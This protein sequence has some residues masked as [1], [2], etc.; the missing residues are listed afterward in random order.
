MAKIF[1]QL[2]EACLEQL[3]T[4]PA[5]STQGRIFTNTTEARIKTDDGVNKRALIRNDQKMILG[6]NA[7]PANNIR[8]HRGAATT[9]QF[10]TGS[11]VTAEG[12]LSTTLAKISSKL[13]AYS[14]AGRPAVGNQG[15]QIW[16]TDAGEVQADTGA[17]WI[18]VGTNPGAGT[19]N[20]ASL[21]VS[22]YGHPV[23]IN[24]T[25]T[26]SVAANALTIAV[27]TQSGVNPS[28]LNPVYAVFR[29]LSATTGLYS[30]IALTSAL[31]ITVPNG[32]SLGQ[33]SGAPQYVWIYLINDAGVIDLGV[34]GVDVFFNETP[35]SAT[36]ISAA[37]TSGSVLYS[38]A[39]HVGAKPTVIVG[40]I[41][42]TEPAAG[43][44]SLSPT[45]LHLNPKPMQTATNW[46]SDGPLLIGAVTLAPT[47]GAT[48]VDRLI[49][50]REGDTMFMR[51][52]FRQTGA[53][54]NG[55][56][57]YLISV[58]A[59]KSIN[60]NLVSI[61]TDANTNLNQTDSM[62][63]IGGRGYMGIN[64]GSRG[65]TFVRHYSATQLSFG[66]FND[67]TGF[68]IWAGNNFGLGSAT[69]GVQFDLA[70]PIVGWSQY[71]P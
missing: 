61:S 68:G 36:L 66:I 29:D 11:D 30:V 21:A 53:G 49:Y 64:G 55:T 42:I 38:G 14:T 6:N 45:A 39:A 54:I 10:V 25:L 4:D 57:M 59:G 41:L 18:T 2:E 19:V 47:K 51:G 44:W 16:N 63:A 23:F 71:G 58:A 48:S 15:R 67:Q 7:T 22:A 9:L 27:K 24:G 50:R 8:L 52:E 32:A 46:V 70:V 20:A 65:H 5:A 12:T 43:V 33:T 17:A 3:A 1:G 40:R 56:G 62:V 69:L 34:S 35:N 60:T 37:A 26:A 31:S 13:E 28:A